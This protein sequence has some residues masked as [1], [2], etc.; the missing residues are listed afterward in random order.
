MA[1]L[2][3]MFERTV[4]VGSGG[5]TFSFTGWKVGWASG[6]AHLIAAVRVVRQHLSYV[7]GGPF[8]VAMAE[9]LR[10]PDDYFTGLRTDLAAR[11]D[12]FTAGIAEIGATVIPSQGTYYLT[13]DIRPLGYDSG[14]DFCLDLPH[15]AGVVAIP[16]QALGD[17]TAAM[18]PFVRWA[19]CKRPEVLDAAIDRLT[20]AFPAR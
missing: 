15:R 5:K 20:S 6:P 16:H 12:R 19:F 3:G 2:P 18:A 17:D 11:R 14:M 4:T 13:T 8:Q 9:G 1:T 7:S 10:L